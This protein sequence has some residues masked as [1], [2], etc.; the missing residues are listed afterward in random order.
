MLY[1]RRG[2]HLCDSARDML[3]AMA[4]ALAAETI[5]C[6]V[7]ADPSLQRLYGDRVPV[8]VVDGLVVLEGCFDELDIMR[9]FH[10]VT[11]RASAPADPTHP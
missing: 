2:C 9:A 4:P 5:A 1:T 11:T 8:L 3:A 10:D 6:D 7:D